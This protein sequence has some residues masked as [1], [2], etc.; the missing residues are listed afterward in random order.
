MRAYLDAETLS[1]AGYRG[2]KSL[3]TAYQESGTQPREHYKR[4]AK[5]SSQCKIL[6]MCKESNNEAAYAADD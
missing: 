6:S 3:M 4:L 5:Q 1:Y 2:R